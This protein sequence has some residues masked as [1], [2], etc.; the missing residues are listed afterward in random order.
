MKT[1]HFRRSS[2]RVGVRH[3]II[4]DCQVKP[5]VP[6]DH[7]RWVGNYIAEKQPDVV[8]QI[9][10]FSDMPSLNSYN[11]GKASAEGQR[12]LNDIETTKQAMNLLMKPI[13]KVKG[14]APR[15]VLTLG[16]H[17]DRIT[18][19]TEANGKFQGVLKL[20][21][22]G[23]AEA[24]WEVVPFLQPI[25]VD[26]ISYCHYFVSGAM[27][28]P[29]SSARALLTARHS[30]AVMGHTQLS[31]IAFHPRSGHVGIFV[32][33]CYLHDEDYLNPQGNVVRRQIVV[34]NEVHDGTA[35]PMFVSLRFLKANYA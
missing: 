12:Y 18:R 3:M 30:S 17:E 33:C 31:D 29:V 14:Y 6:L 9:G 15:M 28:R 20:T 11:V 34:L 27:G 4:P 24:G 16:N 25:K 10:D 2:V 35:D 23:Y 7:L 13:R 26:N 1:T 21:D 32:G 8:I 19:E 22:L 5:G